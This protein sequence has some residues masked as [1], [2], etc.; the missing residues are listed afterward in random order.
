MRVLVVD[1]NTYALSARK[2]TD[3]G[4][5][6][7]PARVARTGIQQYLASELGLKD[8]KPTEIINV[9][10]PAEEVFKPES[11][12]SYEH[13]EITDDHP[14][15]MVSAKNY[16]DF[17]MGQVVSKGSQDG[18]F[19]QIDLLVKDGQAI[20]GIQSG[21]T[22]LSAGYYADYI[23]EKGSHDG[24]DYEF[25]Q[26]NI[27]INHVALVDTARA[28]R[29]AK[30]FDRSGDK[31]MPKVTL[32]NGRAVEMED[33][34]AA[35]LVED[36]IKRLTDRAVNAEKALTAKDEETQKEKA[37]AD[38]AEEELEK[39]KEKSSDSAISLRVAETVKITDAARQLVKDFDCADKSVDQ[40]KLEVCQKL[41]PNRDFKDKAYVNAT[42]D[43]D[44]EK[45]AEEDEDEE[46]KEKEAK[47]SLKNFSKDLGDDT[48][49]TKDT[50]ASRDAA[51]QDFLDKRY[52]NKKVGGK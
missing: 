11:L 21:K 47:D 19:V 51:H 30:I 8:R 38:E 48:V 46:K 40:I 6:S 33:S 13:K 37:R 14:P 52:G 28:G 25:I 44:V 43:M 18:G 4:Y 41:H 17:S 22:E 23:P 24:I 39:E 9:F 16:R 7:A 27:V 42:F 10:R 29:G 5:L 2:I 45:K 12:D 1:R 26:R 31:P 35:A 15:E 34:A 20:K 3:E 49:S 36:S 50:Q 32:D